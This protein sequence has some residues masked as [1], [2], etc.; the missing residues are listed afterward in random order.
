MKSKVILIPHNGVKPLN[1]LAGTRSL[2]RCK[3]ALEVLKEKDFDYII[4]S[5]GL[6]HRQSVQTIPVADLMKNWL[7]KKGIS[8]KNNLASF[9]R[10]NLLRKQLR[11]FK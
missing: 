2:I 11:N 9:S 4:T 10:Q 3:K 8:Q 7:V 6:G 5:G 1:N